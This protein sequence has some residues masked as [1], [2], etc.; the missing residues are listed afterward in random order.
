V[1]TEPVVQPVA[2]KMLT[3]E[4]KL[5]QTAHARFTVAVKAPL[6]WTAETPNLYTVVFT[7]VDK[8]DN[9]VDFESTRFGFRQI[10]VVDGV[11]LVNGKRL[12]V[13]GVNRHEFNPDRGRAVT[14]EDM[15]ADIVAMKQLNFN[16]VRTSHYP[17]HPRWYDLCDE[18]GL[19]VID[20]TNLETHG[21]MGELSNDPRWALAYLDRAQRMVLRDKNHPCIIIWSLGN[22]SGHGPHHAAMKA[23]MKFYDPTRLVQ[24]ESNNPGPEISDVL[25]PMYP[26]LESIKQRLADHT[27]TRPVIL[28]E[29]AYAKGN[30]T[31]NFYKYWEM[32]DH[33]ERFQGGCIW[34]WSDKCLTHLNEKGEKYWAYGGDF[35]DG[36]DFDAHFGE[37]GTMVANGIVAPDLQWHPGAYEVAKVQAPVDISVSS[38]LLYGFFPIEGDIVNGKLC[39]WNKYHSLSLAHLDIF[40]TVT[41]EGVGIQSGQCA[42]LEIGPNEKSDLK[43]PFVKP[44][45][46]KPGAEYFL[47]IEFKLNAEQPWAPKGHLVA[48]EQFKLPFKVPQINGIDSTQLPGLTV[49]DSNQQVT[50][51]GETF[52]LV[53]SRLNGELQTYKFKNQ[54]LLSKGPKEQFF[55]APTDI[56]ILGNNPAGNAGL[57]KKAGLDRLVASRIDLQCTQLSDTIVQVSSSRRLSADENLAGFENQITYTIFG[58]GE[59]KVHH[60]V[61]VEEALPFIPRIGMEM[62]LPSDF[63]NLEY[64]GRGPW[65]NYVDRKKSAL[66]G[67]YTMSVDEQEFPYIHASEFGGHEDTRWLTLTN[68]DNVGLC[69]SASKPFHF[70]AL[71]YSVENL[72]TAEHPYNL[73]KLDEVVLH[74][75]GWHM[76]VGGDD[77]W[78]PKNVHPEFRIN[79][80]EYEY[81]YHLRPFDGDLDEP[82]KLTANRF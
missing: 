70:D 68:G 75:D 13:R 25:C 56:D 12:V 41:E 47:N 71:P 20:E 79:P 31:G 53:F 72:T 1:L 27:E 7:L 63:N 9:R 29:Y 22:E 52:E 39:I 66:V 55:R 62:S 77:G 60:R 65:E 59:I 14:D 6:Q 69:V 19:F 42:P 17:N 24:Y 44:K 67:R 43:I 45:E 16:T 49:N 48:W 30:S 32:V 80:G 74:I 33:Y 11:A 57:W 50:V 81:T 28:C 23:W 73:V 35:N 40:W 2:D 38:T 15:I 34:D 76:G 21:L 64:F 8:D 78:M 37:I 46:L 61:H 3:Y 36:F 18:Y 4:P 26:T 5:Q 58:N 82:R 10:E 51:A 54:V